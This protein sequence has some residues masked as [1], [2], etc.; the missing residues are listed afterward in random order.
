MKYLIKRIL[1]S[2]PVIILVSIMVFMFIHMIP[3]DPI[4][5]LLGVRA[6]PEKVEFLTNKL[7]LDKPIIVQYFIWIKN[8]I[9]GDFGTSIRT[10]QPVLEMIVDRIPVTFSLTTYA[11]LIAMITSIAAGV[12]AGANRNSIYDFSV[13]SFAV[14]GISI[15]QFLMG[16]LLILLFALTL[17]IFPTIGYISIFESPIG[18]LRHM[19]LPAFALAITMSG[20][21][22]RLTRSQMIEVLGQDYIK[23]ARAKGV[24]EISVIFKHALKNA[25][26][27]VVTLAGMWYA[28]TL[29]G[30]ILIEEIFAIPGL[31]RLIIQ[32][33]FN[34]DYP[35]VQGVVLFIAII[36]IFANLVIDL[37]Y[38]Y[39]N[40]KIQL[41]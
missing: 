30:T 29:G 36:N 3:G 37:T 24:K 33:I 27:P 6:T 26:I 25:L 13:I 5:I 9:N 1:Y 11:I 16:I 7:N 39:F 15:P 28:S 38:N 18:F 35:V 21:I 32:S 40:P 4:R 34:R 19:T 31:G 17:G 23:A 12:I 20:S 10:E 2:I 41:K 8:L 22:T 14:L